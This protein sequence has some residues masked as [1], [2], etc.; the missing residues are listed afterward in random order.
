MGSITATQLLRDDHKVAK[1]L[2]IQSETTETRA[3]EMR[4]GVIRE[5]L[6]LLEIHSQLEE[7]FF[8]PELEKY[9]ETAALAV[10]SVEDHEQIKTLI[11]DL[12]HMN[13]ITAE[14]EDQLQELMSFTSFHIE[15]EEQSLFPLAEKLLGPRLE[16]LG[17]QMYS[18]KAELMKSPE[19]RDAQPGLV[20]DPHGGE[21]MRKPF[22]A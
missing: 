6:M 10:V 4:R 12:R 11:K 22:S 7:E 18:R 2:I 19:Y 17:R 15:T 13:P 20:Q 1:G 8:Y 3:P 16:E 14:F 9:P 5:L 21:Q